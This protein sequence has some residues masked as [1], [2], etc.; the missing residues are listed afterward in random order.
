MAEAKAAEAEK[1]EA[2]RIRWQS[3]CMALEVDVK[4]KGLQLIAQLFRR[5][6][7]AKRLQRFVRRRT[8]RSQWLERRLALIGG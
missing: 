5:T 4:R 1:V 6:Q 7:A 3:L 2:A 8:L